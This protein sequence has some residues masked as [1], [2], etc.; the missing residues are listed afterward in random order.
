MA[1]A[2]G[3]RKAHLKRDRVK[4][5]IEELKQLILKRYPEAR[6]EIGLVPESRWPALWV[7][8]N[9]ESALDVYNLVGEIQSDFIGKELTGVYVI[10]IEMNGSDN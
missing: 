2:K 3:H 9:F 1:V 8:A 4:A 10:P 7:Q 6:F 5:H